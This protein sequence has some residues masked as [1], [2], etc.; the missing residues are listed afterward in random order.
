M[1]ADHRHR[2]LPVVLEADMQQRAARQY[3]PPDNSET[4]PGA[5]MS[6]MAPWVFEDACR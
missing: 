3:G 5:A 4:G 2:W 1:E 6:R